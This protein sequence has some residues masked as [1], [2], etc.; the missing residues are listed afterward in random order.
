MQAQGLAPEQARR[1]AGWRIFGSKP[2]AYGAGLQGPIDER[3]WHSRA[4]LAYAYLHW[5][6]YAYGSQDAGTAALSSFSQR[7]SQLQVVLHNQDNR[8]HDLLDSDD[9]YQFEGG[10]I[11]A[12]ETLS[13]APVTAYHADHAQP[14][15]PRIRTLKEE[16]NRVLRSRVVNP[17]WIAGVKRHGYKGAFEL[18]ASVD[19][20]FAF[21]AT[22]QVVDDYQYALVSE[23]YLLDADTR[24]FIQ[25]HNPHALREISERLL[26]AMQRGLW[27][28]PGEYQQRITQLLL[29]SE[30][31]LEDGT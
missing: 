27:Q 7:V 18:A 22:A 25:Q 30:E 6:G 3:N 17:K 21:D 12:A 19:Y 16:I 9:Y 15:Q 13:Q 5:G 14:D 2:G 23:A 29:E 11:A 28:Q 20:L 24:E 10:L 26:E 4:D 31:G 1:Q 8:E